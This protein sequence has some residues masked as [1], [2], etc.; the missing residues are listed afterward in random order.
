MK[1]APSEL[2]SSRLRIIAVYALMGGLWILFS[3]QM[4][5]ALIKDPAI[6]TRFQTYKGWFYVIAT[7]WVLDLLIRR[8]ALDTQRH[9][10][11]LEKT[12]AALREREAHLRLMVEQMGAILWT[13]DTHLRLTASHGSALAVL[14]VEPSQV[15]GQTLFEV[16]RAQ[17]QAHPLIQ[18]H[19]RA[20]RGEPVSIEQTWLGRSFQSRI[21]PL[22]HA[23][24]G[25]IGAIGVSVDITE[26]QRAETALQRAHAELE[27]RVQERTA[28]LAVAKE[29][30]EAA[31]RLKSAFLA[32]MS[33]E[34]RTPLNSIIG[35]TGILLQGLAGPL[36]SEQSKQLG[37]VQS[38]AR[39]LLALINDVLDLSK[40]E[41]G[42]L[43]VHYAPFDLRATLQQ[44]VDSVAPLAAKKRLEMEVHLAPRLEE[45]VSDRRRVEQVVINL[46]NNAVKF[47]EQGRITLTAD[48]MAG[49]AAP[50]GGT[51]ASISQT[52]VRIRVADTGSGIRPE[53]L[54]DLFQPFRQI[55]TGLARR[56]E[57]TGL[58]LA[59]CRRLA[60]LLEAEVQAE[61]QWGRGSVFTFI[62]PLK[63]AKKS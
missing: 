9:I 51:V 4:L 17:D 15:V 46:L 25:V 56:H 53:N 48:L 11:D 36:N 23:E 6:L 19:Y 47:T 35:F 20:L 58:G 63:G 26:R 55:D 13:T 49:C 14:N 38:S 3:D 50:A 5:G 57:G 16:F 33:H 37:M 44:V 7:A 34:L 61:S 8:Y 39:H 32:N 2:R 60:A 45:V 40:I 21:E 18:A 29:R 27:Q 28:E 43:E 42:Q 10:A 24:G 62:L 59:I 12:E 22:R 52:A 1:T 30:A 31:D 41:A 54:E